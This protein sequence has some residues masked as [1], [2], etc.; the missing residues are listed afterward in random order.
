MGGTIVLKYFF[1][2]RIQ[3]GPKRKETSARHHSYATRVNK[4]KQIIKENGQKGQVYV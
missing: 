4:A 1:S 3:N 2:V